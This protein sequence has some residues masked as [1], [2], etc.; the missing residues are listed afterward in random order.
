MKNNK[1]S[2]K[3]IRKTRCPIHNIPLN[4]GGICSKCL[5]IFFSKKNDL[6]KENKD[7]R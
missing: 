6:F 1:L 5:E 7:E 4:R 3:R 2:K